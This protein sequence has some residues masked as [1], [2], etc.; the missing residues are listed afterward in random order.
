MSIN[1]V[2]LLNLVD[3]FLFGLREG[4]CHIFGKDRYE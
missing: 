4:G 3:G 2:I 1:E